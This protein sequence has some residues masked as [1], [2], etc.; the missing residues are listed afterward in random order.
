MKSLELMNK[1]GIIPW[2]LIRTIAKLLVS[3]NKS[4]FGLRDDP[5]SDDWTDFVMN[6]GKATICDDR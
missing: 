6:G 1:N 3:S 5:Y 4:Q 2:S